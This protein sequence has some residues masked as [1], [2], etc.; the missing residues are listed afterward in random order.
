MR[1]AEECPCRR[2]LQKA[3][4]TPRSNCRVLPLDKRYKRFRLRLKKTRPARLLKKVCAFIRL[5]EKRNNRFPNLHGFHSVWGRRFIF[6]HPY[7]KTCLFQQSV[8]VACSRFSRKVLCITTSLGWLFFYPAA[9]RA[10]GTVGAVLA[11]IPCGGYKLTI[12]LFRRFTP[13]PQ[14]FPCVQMKQLSS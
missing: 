5:Q 6:L 3:W 12:L 8:R 7:E 2:T 13:E 1:A 4:P 9:L 14:F 10:A 11:A